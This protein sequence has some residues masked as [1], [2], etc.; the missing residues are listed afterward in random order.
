VETNSKP[1]VVLIKENSAD[2]L[3]S[4]IKKK[5]NNGGN[6]S[7]P[8]LSSLFEERVHPPAFSVFLLPRKHTFLI[9]DLIHYKFKQLNIELYTN[10]KSTKTELEI[11]TVL[12][13]LSMKNK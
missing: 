10:K 4:L 11:E 8:L 6:A 1:Y 7:S 5:Y 9:D 12:H 13:R 2:I 3:E